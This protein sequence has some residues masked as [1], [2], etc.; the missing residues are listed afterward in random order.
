[1]NLPSGSAIAVKDLAINLNGLS[2]RYQRAGTG[3][4]LL[5][6][7]GLMG[8]SFS[9]RHAIPFLA[10]LRTVYA[11]DLPG[12]G[13]SQFVPGMDCSLHASAERML[14]FM[15]ELSIESCDLLGTSHGGAVAMT[16]AGLAPQ[17]I[18]K[19]I[20]VAPA[21]PWSPRGR[22]LIPVLINPMVAPIFLK[23]APHFHWLQEY[24]FRRLIADTRRLRPGTTEGYLERLHSRDAFEYGIS[25]LRSWNGDMKE[26]EA[27]I[28]KIATIPALLIWGDRDG[29]VYP[30]SAREL[31]QRLHNRRLLMLEEVGHL[32]YEEVPEEFNRAV[33]SF[34][35]R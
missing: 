27:S 25:V 11:I 17:R 23:L 7:H 21:N 10:P 2:C 31:K 26:L 15:D 19:L 28:A 5:M 34:L 22:W 8:Y 24:Y 29:A 1:M 6:F 9:W 35:E 30:E 32:P 18:R 14:R 12:T 13:F 3:P 33:A 4:A 16:L 20:L